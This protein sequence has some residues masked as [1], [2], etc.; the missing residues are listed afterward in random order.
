MMRLEELARKTKA[1]LCL[2]CGK[3]TGNCPLADLEHGHSP[4][5]LVARALAGLEADGRAL[6]RQCLTCGACEE[7]CPEGVSFVEFVREVRALLPREERASCP[8][9]RVLAQ[10]TRLMASGG[11]RPRRLEWLEPDL[12]VAS[13]GPVFLFVGCL[14]LFDAVY[15]DLGIRP[16]D[17]A[18]S[19]VR[20]LNRLGIEPVVSP[21]E[22][23][24]GHD[25]LWGGDPGDFRA[26]AEKN[27][28]AIASSGAKTVVTT[29]A[30][31]ARTLALSYPEALGRFAPEVL[32]L[33]SF[34]AARAGDLVFEAADGAERVV[35][36]HDP[37]RLGRHLGVVDE[38][39][40]LLRGLPGVRLEEMEASGKEARCCGT[41]GFLHC[42][43]E[44]RRLQ[45]LRLDEARATGAE[46]LVTACP[47]CLIH[48]AC[49]RKEDERRARLRGDAAKLEPMEAEDLTVLV[50]DALAKT[51]PAAASQGGV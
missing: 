9:H 30:E 4:R 16:T 38:P 51:A 42:D 27:A 10:A 47:K 41:S 44:S 12:R 11:G 20:I 24:C 28:A 33:S 40:A 21:G 39:R 45:T 46:L 43:A 26:L 19:A 50:A 49:A 31:C 25:I 2:A 23:C 48:F 8:H 34:L 36:Y 15:A 22:V 32:H 29:C 5:R 18:R 7:R 17:I 1:T 3:C 37:C 13:E 35:T 6:A 14:P